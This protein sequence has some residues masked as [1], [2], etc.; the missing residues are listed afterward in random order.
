MIYTPINPYLTE[1]EIQAWGEGLTAA[2]H[3]IFT[4]EARNALNP[5]TSGDTCV[6]WAQGYDDG[7]YSPAPFNP[8]EIEELDSSI[9]NYIGIT[10]MH[11]LSDKY[12][13]VVTGT[14]LL[15][16]W[17][18]GTL[19]PE[20]RPAWVEN[21]PEHRRV[22]VGHYDLTRM[23]RQGLY[24]QQVI[25]SGG[26]ELPCPPYTYEY[27]AG[28]MSITAGPFTKWGSKDDWERVVG[29]MQEKV[30]EMPAG[31]NIEDVNITL[32]VSASATAQWTSSIEATSL[33]DNDNGI[34]AGTEDELESDLESALSNFDSSDVDSAYAEV[35]Y[36]IDDYSVEVEASDLTYDLQEVSEV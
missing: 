8:V 10:Y 35:E 3:T 6:A 13:N 11:D 32:Y 25:P 18:G 23:V 20:D 5:Y 27:S 16:T 7:K 29:E 4:D 24:D 36:E 1:V 14:Y 15:Y 28:G 9:R 17:T 2:L 33:V 22:K 12:A 31:L 34:Y 30:E 26:V 19:H 21:R